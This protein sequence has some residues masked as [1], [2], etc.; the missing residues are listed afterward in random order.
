MKTIKIFL[1][2]SEELD[3]DRIAFGNLV[4]RLD[5]MYEKR[6]VRIKLFEWEDYD[7]AFN[8]KRKQ[9]EYNDYV[10]QSDIFLALFHKKAGQFTVEEFDI[11]S[12]EFKDHASPK[13]YT[14][15]K[16]LK[17]GEEETPELKEFKERLF[18]EMGHYWC[19]YDNRESLQ[20]QFVMQLQLVESSQMDEVKVEDGVV[21]IN[22]LPVA[23]M[24]NLKFAAANEDYLRMQTDIQEL[25]KEIEEMQLDLEK[26]QRKLET[27]RAKLEENPDDEDCQEDYKEKKEEV[28]KL[29][30]RLQ[31]KLN[32]YNKL[33]EDFAKHQELLFNTAKRVAKLQGEEINDRIRR[34]IDALNEGLVREANT[35]LNE[36]EV[37]AKNLL[38]EYKQS[39]EITEQK[40]QN[41]VIS[42][43]ELSL[44]ASSIMADANILI[45]ERIK[46]AYDIYK[47]AD[48]IAQEISYDQEKYIEFLWDYYAFLRDHALYDNAIEKYNRLIKKCEDF[49]G[50]EHPDTARSYNYIGLVYSD[51]GHYDKAL[52]YYKQA[53]DIREKVLG[54]EHPDTATSYNNIG[55]IYSDL[56]H[57]D[58]AMEYYK[59]AL[60]IREKVLGKE[61]PDTAGSYNNIGIVY[62]SLG[63]YDMAFEYYKQALE[64]REKILGKEHPDTASSYGNIGIVHS[65]LGNYNKAM[66]YYKQ[67]LRIRE[68]VLGKEHPHTAYSYNS[69]GNVYY[70]LG[71]YD[72]ALEYHKQAL[73]IKEKVLGKEHPDTAMSYNNIGLVYH[74]LGNYDKALE[75]FKLALEIREKVLGKEH[76]DTAGS[77]NNI[78]ILYKKLGNYDKAL[79]YHKKA[80]EIKEKV[81]GIEHPDTANSYYIIG[82]IYMNLGNYDKA[83]DYYKLAAN[84]GYERAYNELAW[85]Y[86]LMGKYE[87][88]LPWAEKAVEAFP[89]NPGI[90]D[91][92]ATVY[93]GLG[94]YDFAMEQFEHCLKLQKEQNASEE[95]LLETEDKIAVL[96]A[97]ISK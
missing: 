6:G 4:R 26:K 67:A 30:D 36:A 37:D 63:H 92:L 76:P 77:Y 69:I 56:G 54:K 71:D 41:L 15:C 27:K 73:D 14:Y 40:R 35:I 87:E 22:G 33:K 65:D 72:K 9:D 45:N 17:P 16:D 75:Y 57:Y 84:Q 49:Y 38:N 90:I 31:P 89:D 74:D 25:R 47:L 59:Q 13:V 85:T 66:E 81:L 1:A 23:K 28:E 24:E 55:L 52:E 61:H 20:F 96:K 46:Q 42:I 44:K 93:Q 79:E 32:K 2:S 48:I 3:Y 82:N 53:L 88:A 95:S 7:S 91:T 43:K 58:M 68:K 80:L 39:K 8:D 12:K 64:I 11:A 18:K 51:L 21:T 50:K 78:G 5:D 94:R 60:D 19:R 86:H 62:Y 29:I 10:R 97:E 83:L 34:A 70:A